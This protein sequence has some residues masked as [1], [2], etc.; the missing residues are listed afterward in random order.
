MTKDE[1]L[2]SLKEARSAAWY[3]ARSAT[4]SASWY[5]AKSATGYDAR[6]AA[7]AAAESADYAGK[8]INHREVTFSLL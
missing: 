7:L 1:I 5:S 4:R 8:R 6:Y 2:K 3:S